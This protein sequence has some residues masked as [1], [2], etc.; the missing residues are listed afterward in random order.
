MSSHSTLFYV[1]AVLTNTVQQTNKQNGFHLQT[2]PRLRQGPRT[3]RLRVLARAQH[4]LP[5]PIRIP[6]KPR[7]AT[8]AAST[9]IGA[10]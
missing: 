6:L 10:T 9:A 8:T 2:L 3:R 5:R 7:A 1:Y 4:T